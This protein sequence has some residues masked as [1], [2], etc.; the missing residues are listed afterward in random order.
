MHLIAVGSNLSVGDRTIRETIKEAFSLFEKYTGISP[1]PSRF[2]STPAFP[3]GSGPDF[4]N[5]AFAAHS[6]LE[7]RQMLEVLHRIEA[8]LGR[9]RQERWGPRV[10]DLDLIA[11]GQAVAPSVTVWQHWHDLSA[12]DQARRAPDTLVL[13]HPRMQDRSFVLGPLMDIAPDWRHPVLGRSVR[14]MNAA[15]PEAER[16]SVRPIA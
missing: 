1:I 13:P 3:A 5:A 8:E 2:F 16:A 10:V 6:P 9:E 4:V 14:E 15:R 7:P 12:D 11:V